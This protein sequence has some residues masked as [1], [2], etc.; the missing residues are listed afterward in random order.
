M[1]PS[2]EIEMY[3]SMLSDDELK[4]EL[5]SVGKYI[6]SDLDEI[7][8]LIRI[9]IAK[10]DRMFKLIEILS[11]DCNGAVDPAFFLMQ[12][13]LVEDLNYC[14]KNGITGTPLYAV[15]NDCA[16]RD[17]R[18]FLL[19]LWGLQ[20]GVYTESEIEDNLRLYRNSQSQE[21]LD[22]ESQIWIEKHG[23]VAAL[24]FIFDESIINPRDYIKSPETITNPRDPEYKNFVIA[25]R[26]YQR[27]LQFLHSSQ[28]HVSSELEIVSPNEIKVT[29]I[30]PKLEM[31]YNGVAEFVQDKDGIPETFV[32]NMSQVGEIIL[33]RNPDK[34]FDIMTK[35]DYARVLYFLKNAKRQFLPSL[36]VIRNFK[37]EEIGDFFVNNNCKRY[38]DLVKN[39]NIISYEAQEGL[40]KLGVILG[41]FSKSSSESQAAYDFIDKHMTKLNG[42]LDGNELHKVFGG[43]NIEAGFKKDFAKFFMIHYAQNPNAFVNSYGE[44]KTGQLYSR[45]EEI[46]E[47]RPEKEIVTNTNTKRLTPEIAMAVFSDIRFMF[48]I[49]EEYK[50]KMENLKGIDEIAKYAYSR[51]EIMCAVDCLLIARGLTPDEIML[52]KVKDEEGH[53]TTFRLLEKG[54]E[55]IVYT[56]RKTNCCFH[57]GGASENSW[58]DAIMSPLSSV[59]VFESP[60]GYSQGWVYY[61]HLNQRFFI[62]NIEG[63]PQ[64]DKHNYRTAY[65]FVDAVLRFAD[66]AYLSLNAQGLPCREVRIGSD[67]PWIVEQSYAEYDKA[68]Q[69]DKVFT[70]DIDVSYPESNN[71]YTDARRGQ[72][73]ISNDDLIKNRQSLLKKAE[74]SLE[75]E[76][77]KQMQ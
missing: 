71:L 57:Y 45:F 13:P 2:K 75:D 4:A 59:V 34:H 51:E 61:D 29:M 60:T 38:G 65:D 74:E 64:A 25:N 11:G 31:S 22:Y 70:D 67:A 35:N 39:S 27:F 23:R 48:K 17:P 42:K 33:D 21:Y 47:F 66:M 20:S 16:G 58:K 76:N 30:M 19:Q 46:L 54:D 69:I 55:E 24:P 6:E 28:L 18:K 5:K 7:V 37:P 40:V 32:V 36:A 52:P 12:I 10:D 15:W 41:L 49:P 8:K 43:I 26:T 44:N 62:D 53:Q 63:R 3:F 68:G 72:Y 50:Q 9:M 73:V 77:K 14:L 56:G 1:N